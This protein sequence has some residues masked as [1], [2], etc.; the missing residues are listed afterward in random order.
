MADIQPNSRPLAG[1]SPRLRTIPGAT[2]CHMHFYMPGFQSQPGGPPIAE[3][4][5][6]EHYAV[7]QQRLGLERV[8]ITQSNAN[9]FDNGS[10]LAAL[11]Q[12]GR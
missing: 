3:Y 11:R 5:T 7:V 4:A 10:T 12:I 8:V 6:P 9:Q 2:D 1:P